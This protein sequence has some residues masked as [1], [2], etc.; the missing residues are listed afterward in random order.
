ML[1][2]DAKKS[3]QI[4]KQ[5]Y[6]LCLVYD[7]TEFT[8]EKKQIQFNENIHTKQQKLAI[9]DF[10]WMIQSLSDPEK[11]YLYPM[12]VERK[13]MDDLVAS[14]KDGRYIEQKWRIQKNCKDFLKIYLVEK[15]RTSMF[16]EKEEL[17]I[18]SALVSTEV[19]AGFLVYHTKYFDQT[20]E[21]LSNWTILIYKQILATLKENDSNENYNFFNQQNCV[22]FTEFNKNAQKNCITARVVFGRQLMCIP[23]V[24][25]IIAWSITNKYPTLKHLI[26]NWNQ[27]KSKKEQK[28]LLHKTVKRTAYEYCRNLDSGII[29]LDDDDIY[30][31]HIALDK[32]NKDILCISK[33]LSTRIWDAFYN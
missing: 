29:E 18:K 30:N 24:S 19:N 33:E 9:G 21:V 23:K 28:L 5:L 25:D 1:Q 22:D 16:T 3:L 2:I 7:T 11:Q 32:E 27:C 6:S 8:N 26:I 12:I 14:I 31:A 13:R 15:C 17:Q 4:E 20:I 10:C